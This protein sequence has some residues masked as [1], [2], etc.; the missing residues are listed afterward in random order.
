M[1]YGLGGLSPHKSDR[2][3]QGSEMW[4]KNPR[5]PFATQDADIYVDS[6]RDAQVLFEKLWKL[7]LRQHLTKSHKVH[8]LWHD[9]NHPFSHTIIKRIIKRIIVTQLANQTVAASI[10]SRFH[11]GSDFIATLRCDLERALLW[12]IADTTLLSL[13]HTCQVWRSRDRRGRQ[14]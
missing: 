8:R 6:V 4:K 10:A 13:G 2:L 11:R 9:S 5:F 7:F 14:W 1:Y 3:E 12:N